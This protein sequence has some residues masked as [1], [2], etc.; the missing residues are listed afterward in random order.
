VG[1][2]NVDRCKLDLAG[3]SPCHPLTR[4]MWPSSDPSGA[5]ARDS[6]RYKQDA[7]GLDMSMGRAIA[8]VPEYFDHAA[9]VQERTGYR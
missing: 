9:R 1:H 7:A 8:K 2:W 5:P 4:L 6:P 3:R